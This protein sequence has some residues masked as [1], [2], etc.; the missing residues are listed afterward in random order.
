MSRDDDNNDG[1]GRDETNNEPEEIEEQEE[2]TVQVS[3]KALD[4]LHEL[5]AGPIPLDELPPGNN[6]HHVD[7]LQKTGLAKVK[8]HDAHITDAGFDFHRGNPTVEV[9]VAPQYLPGFGTWSSNWRQYELWNW[10]RRRE[11][12]LMI[13]ALRE[14]I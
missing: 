10:Q 6:V 14:D 7:S 2:E 1:E 9:P 12:I 13:Q 8:G 5:A 3:L 4:L 11:H